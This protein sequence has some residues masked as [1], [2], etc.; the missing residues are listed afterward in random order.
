MNFRLDGNA[1]ILNGLMMRFVRVVSSLYQNKGISFSDSKLKF[2]LQK[3]GEVFGSVSDFGIA[4]VWD[5]F[6]CDFSFRGLDG[7]VTWCMHG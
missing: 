4:D 7:W 1:N 5:L 2:Q 3:E 6:L